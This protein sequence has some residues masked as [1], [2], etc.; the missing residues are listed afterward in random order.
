[1]PSDVTTLLRDWRENQ[2][3]EALNRL[4][5]LVYD[6]L[7]RLAAQHLRGEAAG[8]TLQPTALVHEVYA[9]LVD[10]GPDFENRAHF[11]GVAARAM[12]QILV[13][14]AR[15]RRREKRGAGAVPVTLTA[16]SAQVDPWTLDLLALDEA[17]GRLEG[18]HARMARAVELH[19]FGGMTQGDA[20][21]VLD[22]SRAT[23]ERDLK[24]ARAWLGEQLQEGP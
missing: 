6:E 5:P 17:L 15:R 8:H 14:H 1:M 3:P 4:F 12:R 18:L 10:G 23:V 19:F 24:L 9:R 11:F 22:V 2:D 21:V 7:R 20:A 16:D 13:D